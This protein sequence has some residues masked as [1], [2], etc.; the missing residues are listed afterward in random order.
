MRSTVIK[1]YDCLY[2]FQT[3]IAIVRQK[4]FLVTI[5]KAVG[6]R[7]SAMQFTSVLVQLQLTQRLDCNV[8]MDL[9]RKVNDGIMSFDGR[10]NFL[11]MHVQYNLQVAV[12][13]RTKNFGRSEKKDDKLGSWL[14]YHT[15]TKCTPTFKLLTH[16][17][18]YQTG[19]CGIC[20]SE[21][22]F[23]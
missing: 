13:V 11:R 16:V 10:S 1:Y 8:L 5:A 4:N 14:K 21:L 7:H 12:S 3:R 22:I 20:Q 15:L 23:L 19:F 6:F 17:F 9:S 18:R 2:S